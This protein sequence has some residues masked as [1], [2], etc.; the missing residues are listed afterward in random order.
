MIDLTLTSTQADLVS[1]TRAAAATLFPR[2][3]AI[4]A[5]L[6]GATPPLNEQSW[7]AAARLGWFGVGAGSDF[8]GLGMTL[9]E[10]L[11]VLIELG[12][13][14]VPGPVVG[15]TAAVRLC[16]VAGNTELGSR[17]VAGDLRCGLRVG[18]F[19][20]EAGRGDFVLDI[21]EG[22]ANLVEVCDSEKVAAIDEAT[23]MSRITR[24]E[25]RLRVDDDRMRARLNVLLGGYLVGLAE[26]LATMSVEY[27]K[28]RKQFGKPIGSFQAVKHRC[29]EMTIRSHVARAQLLVAAL[30][31]ESDIPGGGSFESASGYFLALDAAKR[32]GDDNIQNHGGVGVTAEHA[33]GAY[34]KRAEVYSRLGEPVN[35]LVSMLLTAEQFTT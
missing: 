32:N 24:S 9:S 28:V 11:L 20:V 10:E 17:F 16:A 31:V 25:T 6:T 3:D 23:R 4:E 19:A 7:S 35:D 5:A 14:L 21:T 15:T 29:A 33:A 22:G 27:A 1:A 2:S 8:D 18:D 12:R 34:V 26:A 30:L 13:A